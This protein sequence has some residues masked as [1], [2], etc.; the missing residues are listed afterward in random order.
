M[1]SGPKPLD[2]ACT[3]ISLEGGLPALSAP[4]VCQGGLCPSNWCPAW[5]LALR[6]IL[7]LLSLAQ[8]HMLWP[9]APGQGFQALCELLEQV[10][11]LSRLQ[12]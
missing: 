6:S 1:R 5:A 10:P 11:A 8:K 4:E 12:V 9:K 7:Q 3:G 2:L